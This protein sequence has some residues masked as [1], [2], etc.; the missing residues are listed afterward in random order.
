MNDQKV[1]RSITE[2]DWA[3]PGSTAAFDMLESFV[4]DR[5]KVFATE[6]NDPTKEALSNISPWLH[7]GEQEC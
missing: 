4:K 5:L 1:D 7:F 6:R 3:T 2:V